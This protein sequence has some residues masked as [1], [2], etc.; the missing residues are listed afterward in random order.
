MDP[1]DFVRARIAEDR[2]IVDVAAE[3]LDLCKPVTEDELLEGRAA[4]REGRPSGVWISATRRDGLPDVW[5][6]K[7]RP[8][9][10]DL[11][12]RWDIRRARE[13]VYVSEALIGLHRVTEGRVCVTCLDVDETEGTGSP[14][15]AAWPCPTIKTLTWQWSD[16]PDFEDWG[17]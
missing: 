10:V 15:P 2:H 14:T 5:V 8:E 16:H 17:A 3:A 1:R 6:G 11:T 4:K 13:T 9:L 12:S 7:P